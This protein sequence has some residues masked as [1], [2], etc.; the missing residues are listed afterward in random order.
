MIHDADRGIRDRAHGDEDR[1]R[2]LATVRLDGSNGATGELG[3]LHHGAREQAWDP[4]G[5]GALANP[6][7]HVAVLVLDR[8]GHQGFGWVE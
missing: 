7:F 1:L 6:A 2:V 5:V 8:A 3:P 4:L